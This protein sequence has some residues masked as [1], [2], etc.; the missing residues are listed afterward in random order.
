[1]VTKVYN[2]TSRSPQ[3][4]LLRPLLRLRATRTGAWST[5][6]S[7]IRPAWAQELSAWITPTCSQKRRLK[8]VQTRLWPATL[9]LCQT[10]SSLRGLTATAAA[11][12]PFSNCMTRSFTLSL[13]TKT[14][15]ERWR[16]RA[17]NHRLAENVPS[18]LRRLP[19][20]AKEPAS[21]SMTKKRSKNKNHLTFKMSSLLMLTWIAATALQVQARR[22]TRL[23]RSHPRPS[24]ARSRHWLQSND[25]KERFSR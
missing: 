19:H 4:W 14:G 16:A 22:K 17:K 18:L 2:I 20:I 15:W 24:R 3:L 13:R 9:K 8:H 7:K 21:A 25:L 10:R 6:F 12:K 5:R 23:R 1:M 11:T